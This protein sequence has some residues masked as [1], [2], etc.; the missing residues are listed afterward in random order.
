MIYR[1]PNCPDPVRLRSQTL[2]SSL[3]PRVTNSHSEHTSE[4][5]GK[6]RKG[7]CPCPDHPAWQCLSPLRQRSPRGWP[8]AGLGSRSSVGVK[9]Q[10]GWEGRG[11]PRNMFRTH[12]AI[13]AFTVTEAEPPNSEGAQGLVFFGGGGVPLLAQ[14]PCTPPLPAR[15]KARL[16]RKGKA[17]PRA[18]SSGRASYSELHGVGQ[19]TRQ[20]HQP[21][22]VTSTPLMRLSEWKGISTFSTGSKH[23]ASPHSAPGSGPRAQ[24]PHLTAA[25]SGPRMECPALGA[26]HTRPPLPSVPDTAGCWAP[27]PNTPALGLEETWVSAC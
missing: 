3:F 23:T 13:L 19:K 11:A 26:P 27:A 20:S 5:R 8:W 9:G 16:G 4:P 22:S 1:C 15:S 2:L 10:A 12:Q 25:A 7:K 24:G 17:G 14:M 18:A 21:S 6:E